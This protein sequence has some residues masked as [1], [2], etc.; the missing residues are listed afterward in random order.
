[1]TSH[2]E[3]VFTVLI[4]LLAATYVYGRLTERVARHAKRIDI[5]ENTSSNHEQRI[6]RIEGIEMQC[7]LLRGEPIKEF[8]K[9]RE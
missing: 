6:S 2:I 9:R 5:L 1:M 8:I 7:P 4:Q 3:L